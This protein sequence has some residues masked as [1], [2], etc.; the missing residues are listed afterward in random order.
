MRTAYRLENFKAF[1]DTG[2]LELAPITILCGENSIGKSSILKSLLLLRQSTAE[3]RSRL[4]RNAPVQPFLFNGELTRL[5]SWSDTVYGKIKKRQIRMS[6]S[7]SGDANEIA[8]IGRYPWRRGR[9]TSF[10]INLDVTLRSVD[11][12]IEEFSTVLA[13]ASVRSGE[14]HFEFREAQ[15]KEA[16]YSG[17]YNCHI[18]ELN[19]LLAQSTHLRP[20]L[21]SLYGDA[22]LREVIDTIRTQP[23]SVSTGN[24]YLQMEGPFPTSV[25]PT[26]N[27]SWNDFLDLISSTVIVAR[28][29]I[30]GPR[31]G[32]L[33]DLTDSVKQFKKVTQGGAEYIFEA[34][35]Q[36]LA[37]SI[38]RMICS[39]LDYGL[40]LSSDALSPMWKR[41]RYL[42]PL[43]SQP[44]R[45]YQFDDTGGI[46]IGVSGEF[47]VQVLA[48][49]ANNVSNVSG[50][51]TDQR[52]LIS[53]VTPRQ[54]TLLEATNDWLGIMGL[55][56]VHPNVLRQSLYELRV[57]AL[58]VALPDVGFGVSQVLPIVVEALRSRAGDTL[59]LEQPE[60]H[61]H[62]K[63]QASLADF[64]IARANDGV[65]FIVESH[66]EYLVKR[67]CRRISEGTFPNIA[68]LINIVFVDRGEDN[69]AVCKHV[70]LNEYGEIE[71]WPAGFFDTQE[72][73]YWMEAALR[74]RRNAA[75]T[76]HAEKR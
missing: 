30:R 32:W 72:D 39:E 24:L 6:W 71:N 1:K 59:I 49:E 67:L 54:R 61:L 56:A 74:R 65:K 23:V 76:R 10:D 48:L 33:N 73:L 2:V 45:F 3:R 36:D 53:L 31:P 8:N 15:R 14:L 52:G 18:Q 16:G 25:F 11:T 34:T 63:V 70:Q 7:A 4:A 47:T 26:L 9:Q 37:V 5:G 66:S 75:S 68:N 20:R 22:R 46:D 44:Q 42:G 27:S 60:I 50:L 51:E 64:L 17:L 58:D 43:R 19:K 38:I 35:K 12:E 28:A 40:E 41:L 57:G 13:S 21:A 62:P 55:P 29:G 69:T